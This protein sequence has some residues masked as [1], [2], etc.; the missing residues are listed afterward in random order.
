MGRRKKPA[1]KDTSRPSL[2]LPVALLVLAGALIAGLWWWL[3]KPVAMPASPLGPD[4]KLDCISYAPF[5]NGQ[6]PF[7]PTTRIERWQIEDDL[8]RLSRLSNCVRTYSTELG[9]DQIPEVAQHYGM[10]VILGLWLGSKPERN[11]LER[12]TAIALANRYPDVVTAVVVGNEVLLRGEMAVSDLVNTI[13]SVKAE[14]RQPVTYADVWEFWLRHRDVKDAVDF[15]TIHILPYWEDFPVSAPRAAAH[16]DAIHREIAKAFP[17]KEILIGETGWPSAGRM[18][19]GALPSPA[20]QA[21]VLHE[22]LAL[23]K[24]QGYRVNVIEAFDQPWKRQLEGTVGGHWGL[25][26]A[27][28][29]QFKFAWGVPV[30]DHPFWQWQAAG[31]IGF[32]IVIFAAAWLAGRGHRLHGLN[33]VMAWS[34]VAVNAAVGGGM[35]GLAIEKMPLESLG[36]GGWLRS[37]ALV[38][39]ALLVPIVS[40]MALIHGS[41]LPAYAQIF[42]PARGRVRAPLA[43][44]LGMLTAAVMTLAILVAMGLVFDPRYR[45]FPFAPLTGAIVPLFVLSLFSGNG[46]GARGAA[47]MAAAA[48]LTLSA[49]YIAL[50]ESSTNWQSLWLCGLLLAQAVTLWRMRDARSSE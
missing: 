18:R 24:R 4:G 40:S 39:A 20:N 21:L 9:L 22:V 19:E 3:G 33:G 34:A 17:G 46:R 32:A 23:A 49:I 35:I 38:A 8:A 45:D 26:D 10:K 12:E 27:T 25:L 7:D 48:T 16:V 37:V 44:L 6:S 15:V 41:R 2:R 36:I 11:K 30:S 28:T 29:R 5:R 13:R 42:G 31:G 1:M 43:R 50:N 47:E 14:I